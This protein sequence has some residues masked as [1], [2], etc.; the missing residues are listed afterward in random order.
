M[1]FLKFAK[2]TVQK[3]GIKFAEW[4]ALRRKAI[5]PDPE[6]QM[7]TARV[8]LD[9]YDP[10]KYML[11]HATIVASVDVDIASAPTGKHYVEGFEIDRPFQDYYVTAQTQR[12]INNNN[13]CFERKLLMASFKTFVG[14]QSYIEHVQIPE[15]SQGRII[16][17]AARDIGDSLYVDILI[18]NDLKHAAL[19]RSIKSGQLGTLSMGCFVA[20]TQVT[21]FDGTRKAI[22]DVVVGDRVLTHRG[23]HREVT[24]R[25]IKVGSFS[26]KRVEV[27]GVPSAI[28]ATDNHPFFVL[29]QQELCSCG[30]GELLTSKQ[31]EEPTR[32]RTKRFKR[33][34]QLRIYNPA[35]RYSPEERA[36]RKQ[37]LAAIRATQLDL[38]E[39]RADQLC[40][41][42]L[43]CFPKVGD[44]QVS[45]L[46]ATS[47]KA[48]LLGYFIAE[49]SFLKYG[50]RHSEVQ[51]NFALSER[52]TYVAE[53]VRLLREEFPAAGEPWIQ[54]RPERDTCVV[55]VTG[56]KLVQWFLRH[57]GEYSDKKRLSAEVMA[58]PC[59]VQRH[60][61]G[62]WLNGDGTIRSD[63]N[64]S[65]G[66]TTSY[67][68][69]CQLHQLMMRCGIF[70]RMYVKYEGRS[71]EARI[72]VNG[73]YALR[74]AADGRL[75]SFTLNTNARGAE[76]LR[77]VSS[78]VGRTLECPQWRQTDENVFFQVCSVEDLR[79]IGPVHDMTVEEDHSYIVEGV[80]VHNCSTSSTTCSKCGN[81]A[82]D[83]TQLCTCIRYF[84]GQQFVDE[85][86]TQ[87]KI[88][89]L[90]GHYTDPTSVRFIEASWV[91]NP[92]FK[93]AVLRS[94]LSADE[95]AA[96]ESKLHMA[97]T[98]P[99][100]A[101][102]KGGVAK[103][104]RAM[105]GQGQGQAPA[106]EAPAEGEAPEAEAPAEG[107]APAAPAAPGAPAAPA[108]PAEEEDPI[109]KAVKDLSTK[110]RD[111][112]I[113]QVKS[114]IEK[115]KPQEDNVDNN[116]QNETLIRSALLSPKW[117]KIAKVV[118]SFV[119]K[120][121]ARQV[122]LGLIHHKN[123]GWSRVKKAGLT[124]R[125]IL[126]VSRVVDKM[127][128][129]SSM[130]G[131]TRVY[132]TVLSVGGTA[133]YEDEETYLAACRQVL[134]R[135]MTGSE[136]SQL[137]EKGRLYALGRS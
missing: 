87:R 2:A 50:G 11:S 32:R 112:A 21:M 83:E 132:R 136:A 73:G 117:R 89:E 42:D 90:C 125:E 10:S 115:G 86:D 33:G 30:C 119:G 74:G 131:E 93:G 114:E 69:A 94:V 76:P 3:P 57:G 27:T 14:A 118:V 29:R 88:A 82:K 23:R 124:G 37:R 13:D 104:A 43:V 41:G 135:V 108:A 129:Q 79:Y 128:K 84:K 113:E 47:G 48:R 99:T 59:A 12:F 58:W 36:E 9:T 44:A 106:E 78:K 68:L 34:H 7:R 39:V 60:L 15:L 100:P 54:E 102:H 121:H 134:G 24:A 127:T 55:H 80:A 19:I 96:V 105:F 1:S 72:A 56:E 45:H 137:L 63:Q 111:Q 77:A 17:A 49:G 81:V 53:V 22:E 122:L 46:D 40:P 70:A 65:S 97:F 71:S 133:P 101:P 110:L 20:G 25:Q 51:F 38:V 116:K 120:A 16:D 130:A 107:Q 64:G 123:G 98:K 26:M 31:G 103:A 35:K 8:I 28:V 18:A 95:V 85:F 126:A 6:F 67:P 92:A 61:I 91:A 52:E 109:E 75:A 66:T 5:L 62:A 4:D